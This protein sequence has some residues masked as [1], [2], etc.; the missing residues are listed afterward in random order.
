LGSIS[1]GANVEAGDW[2][3]VALLE[4]VGRIQAARPE[5]SQ[6]A[7]ITKAMEIIRRVRQQ[8]IG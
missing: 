8:S 1:A 3:C 7:A 6:S 2:G 4:L 5:M